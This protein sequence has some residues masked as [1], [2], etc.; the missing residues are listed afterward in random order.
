MAPENRALKIGR[1]LPR[2]S[3]DDVRVI[4]ISEYKAASACLVEAFMEDEAIRYCID[5][6]DTAHFSPERK[7]K[8]YVDNMDYV[9]AAHIYN[10][11]VTTIGPNHASVAI[12]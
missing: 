5:T 11:L 9:T 10:G 12:W 8:L 3:P 1:D 7:Q 4:G 6:P 2:P